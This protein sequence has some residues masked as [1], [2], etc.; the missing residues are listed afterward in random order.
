TPACA[1]ACAG[2]DTCGPSSP[3]RRRPRRRSPHP[4]PHCVCRPSWARMLAVPGKPVFDPPRLV[5]PTPAG[6]CRTKARDGR[7][8]PPA[9]RGTG[10]ASPHRPARRSWREHGD[11][12]GCANGPSP[13]VRMR[14]P[15]ARKLTVLAVSAAVVSVGA[16]APPAGPHDPGPPPAKVPVAVG[17]GGAVSSVDADASAAGIEVLR[18]G[19]N[20]VD[21]AVATAAALGVTEPYSAGIGGGGYFVYYDARSRSVHTLDGRETAPLTAGRDLFLEDG[22]P[23]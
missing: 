20:A 3:A 1:A 16:T 5:R 23:I 7:G 18:K 11:V 9:A 22:E 10:A 4:A 17:H 15:V 12:V 14:R 2:T 8:P 21:A 19:G 6:R 13:E